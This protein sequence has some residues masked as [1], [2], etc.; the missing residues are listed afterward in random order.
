[1]SNIDDLRKAWTGNLRSTDS[2]LDRQFDSAIRKIQADA[3]R[4]IA[5]EIGHSRWSDA[6]V[7]AE[8]GAV[9]YLFKRAN[10]I[11]EH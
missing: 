7:L 9:E 3:V 4:G 2:A 6:R 11:E 5:T 1:M 10:E 8:Y